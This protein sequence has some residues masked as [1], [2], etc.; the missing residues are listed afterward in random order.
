MTFSYCNNG[1]C[2]SPEKKIRIKNDS[3][4]GSIPSTVH[5][6]YTAYKQYTAGHC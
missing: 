6:L 5:W 3:D 4:R 1:R 2:T